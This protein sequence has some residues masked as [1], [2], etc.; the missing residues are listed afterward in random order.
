MARIEGISFEVYVIRLCL[1]PWTLEDRSGPSFD[2][3]RLPV[4]SFA[5]DETRVRPPPNHC[6]RFNLL[7]LNA[8][9]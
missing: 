7:L 5:G 3:G 6:P 4:R 8:L 2:V 9:C 1:S